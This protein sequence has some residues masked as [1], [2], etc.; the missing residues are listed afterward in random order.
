MQGV[1]TMRRDLVPVSPE[2]PWQEPQKEG[3]VASKSLAR[4]KAMEPWRFFRGARGVRFPGAPLISKIA[5]IKRK[6]NRSS[7]NE[8]P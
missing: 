7:S 1:M 3:S 6:I 2:S 5:R 4:C 8:Y